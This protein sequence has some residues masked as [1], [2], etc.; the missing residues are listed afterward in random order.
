MKELERSRIIHQEED[1]SL[2]IAPP[3]KQTLAKKPTL[4]RELSRSPSD[5]IGQVVV[6]LDH[7][8]D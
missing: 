1:L 8:E 2:Y 5:T 6:N 4:I 3:L 7:V